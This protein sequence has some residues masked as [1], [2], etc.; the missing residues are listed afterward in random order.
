MSLKTTKLVGHSGRVSFISSISNHFCESC[1]RLRITSNG[2]LKLC[3]FSSGKDELD[4]K[5]I[6]RNNNFDDEEIASLIE[7]ALFNKEFNHPEIEVLNQLNQ[8]MLSIGG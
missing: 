4:L 6:L 1:N 8:N 2:K 7:T 5:D 3:L